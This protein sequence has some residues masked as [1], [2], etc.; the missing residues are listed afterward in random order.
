MALKLRPTGLGAGID[1]DRQDFTVYSGGWAVGRIYE[2]RGGPDRLR[3]FW[4]FTVQGPMTRADK[5]ATLEEAKAQFHKSWDAWKAWAKLEE[6][7]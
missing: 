1:K 3:W 4:S 6:V 7:P 2:T 5:V